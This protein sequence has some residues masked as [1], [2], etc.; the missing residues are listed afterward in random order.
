M[1]LPRSGA[2]RL[3]LSLSGLLLLIGCATCL[4]VAGWWWWSHPPSQLVVQS[5]P[6]LG[7]QQPLGGAVPVRGVSAA[8]A[9][10]TTAE[11]HG[12]MPQPEPM[13][14]GWRLTTLEKQH[15]TIGYDE[16]AKSPAW[17]RYRLAG[18]LVSRGPEHRLATFATDFTTSAHVS[19]Q[20]YT[21]SGY[22]R[23]H[24]CPAFAEF[25]RFGQ[26]GLA[27]TF[28]MSNVIPQLHQ[29]NAGVW[30]QLEERI[31][32]NSRSG[33]GGWAERFGSVWVVDGP[34]YDQR[35]ARARLRNG[36]WIPTA[37][38]MLVTHPGNAAPELLGFIVPN[39]T[40]VTG[41]I[42]RYLV[43]VE[44]IEKASG[45]RLVEDLSE[46]QRSRMRGE[47]AQSLW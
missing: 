13:S 7:D 28:I 20:D 22:D 34:L 2:V 8:G 46:P 39:Q 3:G 38:W 23:G 29:V 33:D 1:R 44:T 37:C 11:L 31:A 45:L 32:G 12:L 21:G 4:G 43:S 26:E 41:P 15:F 14:P 17:V 36:T 27:A 10:T 42:E 16:Q 6:P 24:L 30:E 40:G 19:H 47:R 18:P 5:D 9:P 35:P 25:S